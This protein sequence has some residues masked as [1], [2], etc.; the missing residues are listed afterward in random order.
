MSVA[1]A[2]QIHFSGATPSAHPQN[3]FGLKQDNKDLKMTAKIQ[4]FVEMLL[5]K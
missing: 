5:L 2:D 3:D 1:F 4:R